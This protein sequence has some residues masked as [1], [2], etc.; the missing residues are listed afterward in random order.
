MVNQIDLSIYCPSGKYQYAGTCYAYATV[1]S[2]M[3]TEFNIQNNVTDQNEIEN[4]HYSAGVVASCHNSSLIFYKRSKTCDQ[5]GTAQKALNILKNVGTVLIS[6][7]D[8]SCMKFSEVKRQ[9]PA[10]VYWQKITDYDRLEVHNRYSDEFVG[11]I[12]S[13]LA[14]RHP[15]IIGMWQNDFV[16]NL[17]VPAIDYEL[18]DQP[19]LDHVAKYPKG[20]SNHAACI[21][22]FDDQY[23]GGTKGYFLLKNNFENWGDGRGFCWMPYSYLIPM[24]YEA[25]YIKGF[26]S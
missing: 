23:N 21:L 18:P 7:F 5:L 16:R 14:N 12:K 9:V 20:I 19:T 3:S 10:N 11:W 6:D 8:C 13:A 26:R 22:G 2:G 15:V 24:I 25:Y 1:Y 17:I 4:T